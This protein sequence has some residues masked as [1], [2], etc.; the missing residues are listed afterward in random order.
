MNG[1]LQR[2]PWAASRCE[3]SRGAYP[4][5]GDMPVEPCVMPVEFVNTR[6]YTWQNGGA[7]LPSRNGPATS[8]LR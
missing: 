3:P 4:L 2:G 8:F 5:P 1:P 7:T 6:L